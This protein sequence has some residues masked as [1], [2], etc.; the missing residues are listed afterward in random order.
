MAIGWRN[1]DRSPSEGGSVWHRGDP[2]DQ[3]GPR[4]RGTG[5]SPP[6]DGLRGGGGRDGR[7]PGGRGGGQF[8]YAQSEFPGAWPDVGMGGWGVDPP[9]PAPPPNQWGQ[10]QG[11]K[12]QPQ[13]QQ[14]AAGAYP[15]R[16]LDQKTFKLPTFPPPTSRTFEFAHAPT[17]TLPEEVAIREQAAA[18]DRIITT[19]PIAESFGACFAE[20]R[21]A[22][23]GQHRPSSERFFWSLPNNHDDRVKSLLEWIDQ[24]SWPL[25]NLGVSHRSIL[26]VRCPWLMIFQF[27]RYKSYY[28]RDHEVHCS[29]T[30]L[31]DLGTRRR[32]QRSTL[33][34]SHSCKRHSIQHYKA[35][36]QHSKTPVIQPGQF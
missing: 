28:N 1:P 14:G 21:I 9:A 15:F 35:T 8:D 29:R 30:R 22:F 2:R 27:S 31:S 17:P 13:Q 11:Q 24:M 7:A 16:G 33:C 4:G 23:F 32:N 26:I 25:A 18:R 6:K 19:Y 3:Q 34:H 10:K 36:W 20:A 5:S 12:Q